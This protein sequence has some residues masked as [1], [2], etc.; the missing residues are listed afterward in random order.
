METNRQQQQ[1]RPGQAGAGPVREQQHQ[2]RV[3]DTDGNQHAAASRDLGRFS[4]DAQAGGGPMAMEVAKS[5]RS[6]EL[7]RPPGSSPSAASPGSLYPPGFA[8]VRAV[9]GDV[10]LEETS[11]AEE[12]LDEVGE[13]LWEEVEPEDLESEV[14][15]DGEK[16]PEVT[17]EELLKLDLASDRHEVERLMQMGAIHHP[18]ASEDLSSYSRLTTKVVRD[19]RKRPT[20]VRRSRLVAREFKSWSPCTQDFFAPASSLAICHGLIAQAQA[21]GLELTTL[22][23]KDAYLNVPQKAPVVIEIDSRVFE[24]GPS[25]MVPFVLERLL[26][27]QRVA[28]GEWFG[29]IT[30]ILK[31]A[32]LESFP[33][34]PTLFRG[35]KEGDMTSLVLHADDGLLASTPEARA[36]L[37]AKLE[38]K[39]VVQFSKPALQVGDEFEFLKRRYVLEQDGV[40][41]FSNNKHLEGLVK[42]LGAQTR[43]RET[44]A[45]NSFLEKDT[46]QELPEHKARVFRECLGRLL[47]LSHSRPDVQFATCAL[48]SSMAKPTTGAMKRLCRTVGYLARV[49]MLG[50]LIK[51][52]QDRAC[53]GKPSGVALEPGGV[54]ILESVTDADWGGN[55]A[56]RRTSKTSAQIYLGGSLLSSFV[57]S[58]RSVALSS[59]ESEFIA[60]VAGA[61][62]ML[63]VKECMEFVLKGYAT[64]EATA[65]TDSAASRGIS[66]RIGCGRVRHLDCGL[67]W[68]QDAVKRGLLRVGPVGLLGGFAV[69]R[70]DLIRLR[71][72]YSFEAGPEYS[73]QSQDTHEAFGRGSM[74]P[75]VACSSG[76]GIWATG[77][78]H[79][80]SAS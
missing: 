1:Q 62:E 63:Y 27:G 17:P 53:L 48:A 65:R 46:S 44:P 16:P 25:R 13:S 11:C 4:N 50:F 2:P 51:P 47:Y 40:V 59:G 5:S 9:H 72:S 24:E 38:E 71:R 75:E 31:E 67:L 35:A 10:C 28:A 29:F 23:V 69:E 77:S 45:D 7:D 22:D 78:S 30:G 49:P 15:H 36:H 68:L 8:G 19:W 79:T 18:K 26:P 39:V 3:R 42:A 80:C 76:P 56:D 64:I 43:F 41:M 20:W 33:K 61:G 34:E 57:R 32:G 55:K 21:L 58:Q 6:L 37:K 54:I 14:L 12:W 52:V 66:Q 60:T 70:Q 73:A 74:L